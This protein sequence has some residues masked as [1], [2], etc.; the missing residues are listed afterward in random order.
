M[1]L[2]WVAKALVALH[3]V[4]VVLA[5]SWVETVQHISSTGAFIGAPG[6]A[7]GHMN[8]TDAGFADVNVQNKILD[9]TSNP[10]LCRD[11]SGGGYT[12]T[13]YPPLTAAPGDTLAMTWL[14]NGHVT[15]P[16]LT[17]RGYRSGNVMIYGTSAS[18]SNISVNDALYVWNVD[19]TGGDQNGK[20]LASHFYDDGQCYQNRGAAGAAYPIWV[21]RSAK[22]GADIE[23]PCRA[24]FQLPSDLATSG[25]YTV[26][27]VWDWP[28]NPNEAGNTT[29]IY[30]SCATINLSASSSSNSSRVKAIKVATN[31]NVMSAA[32]Q[33]Q[34]A[35]PVEVL[36]RGTGTSSPAAVAETATATTQ[37][38]SAATTTLAA[39]SS[40]TRKQGGIK[41]VTVTASPVRITEYQTVTVD[42]AGKAIGTA[43]GSVVTVTN[44]VTATA[45]AKATVSK[46]TVS[47]ATAS[48]ELQN[49]A[50]SNGAGG[51]VATG[52][53][54]VISVTPFLAARATGHQRRMR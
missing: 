34:I 12:N 28:Q 48:P 42:S 23:L 35:T 46:A 39:S 24:S 18:V 41:T 17:S 10:S 27:W 2:S 4:Q 36:A 50:S 20:L 37:S 19:G 30:T 11:F 29:E 7:M 13:A 15:D 31:L 51:H 32:L 3:G 21:Q 45:T 1:A 49:S 14:E 43:S 6:Y 44:V 22:Y 25:T 53:V 54:D 47:K 33:S 38:G 16:T 26:A 52:S 8:R 40:K 9:L 5:H